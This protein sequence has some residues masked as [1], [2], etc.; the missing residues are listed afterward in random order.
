MNTPAPPSVSASH[1]DRVSQVAHWL[2]QAILSGEWTTGQQLPS[3]RDI[4]A[5][6]GVS[7]SVVREA[8]GRLSSLGLVRSV[9][10][11]GTRVETPTSRPITLGFERLLRRGDL[12]LAHLSAIRLP[13]ETAI[14]ELAARHRSEE[15]LR[16]MAATQAILDNPHEEL[17]TY[18][19]ADIRFHALLADATGN[20]LFQIV[21]G[22][23]QVLLRE[24]RR[25]TLSLYGAQLAHDH[26]GQIL[27]AV[28]A[29]DAA[30]A[31][32]AMRLHLE[33][34]S[35]HVEALPPLLSRE[36]G[37]GREGTEE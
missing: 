4:S 5:R 15:H 1:L 6:L 8:L 32:Q 12:R 36:E 3:E 27:A 26:H 37:V 14:A 24:S 29:G 22:P 17:E 11:S 18:I 10:G 13:L 30:A 2:E 21:L 20:P 23:I 16:A 31:A 19:E 28:R 34:N 9:H 33:A 35:Q 7:R 25:H